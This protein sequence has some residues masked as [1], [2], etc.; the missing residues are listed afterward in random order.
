VTR[1]TCV[2]GIPVTHTT[3]PPERPS[4]DTRFVSFL[5]LS[6][7]SDY[8]AGEQPVS[9]RAKFVQDVLGLAIFA[10]TLSPF[11]EMLF[12]SDNSIFVSGRDTESTLAFVLLLVELSFAIAR[13]LAIVRPAVLQCVGI[14]PS[15]RLTLLSESV[16]G[17]LPTISPPIPLRI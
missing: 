5:D 15:R 2:Q 14:A 7:Q 3:R 12:H 4:P 9:R 8:L 17:V 13:L 1:I 6:P 16:A 11:V 10:C